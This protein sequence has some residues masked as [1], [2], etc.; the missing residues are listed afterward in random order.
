MN[1]LALRAWP[2]AIVAVI[3]GC[4]SHEPKRAVTAQ[5]DRPPL[6]D[7]TA[8][9]PDFAHI[10]AATF[11]RGSPISDESSEHYRLGDKPQQL[12]D[13]DTFYLGRFLVTTEQFCRFLN[14]ADSRFRPTSREL[15][16]LEMVQQVDGQYRPK[17]AMER[18]PVHAVTWEGAVAYCVWLTRRFGYE[19]RLPTEAEWEL[20]ARGPELRDWPWG[21]DPPILS[22]FR[23]RPVNLRALRR[24]ADVPFPPYRL[25]D[26]RV[27]PQWLRG[28]RWVHFSWNREYPWYYAPVGSFP[29]NAT[30]NGVYDMLGYVWGEWCTDLD[31]ERMVPEGQS[32][33]AHVLRGMDDVTADHRVNLSTLF[34]ALLPGDGA[35]RGSHHIP[36]RSWSR[37]RR[38]S[39]AGAMFRV[40]SSDPRLVRILG[41]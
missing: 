29:R 9:F 26:E 38:D 14:D 34:L 28:V 22:I 16:I 39:N 20:A 32:E 33:I 37:E 24:N 25:I 11:L 23:D 2:F 4:A 6:S 27:P 13:V 21:N 10:P 7:V 12:I 35:G 17:A 31:G 1:N 8:L 3:V 41:E 30:P 40:A 18:C 19:F 15:A 5:V 36:G